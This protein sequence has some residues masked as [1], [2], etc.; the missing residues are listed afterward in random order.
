MTEI[1]VRTKVF[2]SSKKEKF[3]KIDDG[4]F[5]IYV[6]EPA[7]RNLANYRVRELIARNFSVSISQVQMLTGHHSPKKTMRVILEE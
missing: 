4:Q 5:E 3:I 1:T 2:P 6:R 7:Q